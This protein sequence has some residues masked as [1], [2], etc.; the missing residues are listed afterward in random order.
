[1]DKNNKHNTYQLKKL[2]HLYQKVVFMIL[3]NKILVNW[4][5]NNNSLQQQIILT[6]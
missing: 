6:I 5:R 3:S 4:A 2:I 1:M